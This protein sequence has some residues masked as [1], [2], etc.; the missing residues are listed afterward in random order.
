MG[1]L[2]RSQNESIETEDSSDYDASS[3]NIAQES[4]LGR[5]VDR[6]V[7]K[8]LPNEMQKVIK[9]SEVDEKAQ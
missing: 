5:F 2:K 3:S 9:K 6:K 4:F 7:G 8:E 1:T